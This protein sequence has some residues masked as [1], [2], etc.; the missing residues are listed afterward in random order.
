MHRVLGPLLI[1]IGV[2]APARSQGLP[3]YRSVNPAIASRS[4]LGFDPVSSGA[5]GWHTALR[6]DYGNV[7]EAQTRERADY[8]LDAELIRLNFSLARNVG[9]W[10]LSG[11]V[12]IESGQSGALDSYINWWHGIFGFQEGRREG[13][14][15]NEYEYFI[16]FPD[17]S[18][19]SPPLPGTALGDLRLSA[20]FKHKPNW[21]TTLVAA[22]PTNTRPDG[23]GLETIAVGI[24]TAARMELIRDRL[25]WEG[26]AGV[27]Y[28]PRAGDLARWQQPWVASATAGAR[29]RFLGRQSIY[30]NFLFHTGPWQSTTLSALGGP[31]FALDFGFLLKPGDGGPEILAGMV[32]DL[33]PYGPA[34][35]LVLRL[36]VRW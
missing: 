3:A 27:G 36:G 21:Q 17:S 18:R 4:P 15:E 28:T 11:A 30:T 20:G 31:D 13:R 7:L 12:P 29:L 1:L 6:L 22:F 24:E 5:P 10:H 14:P 34:V 16:Q 23:W 33:Y 32:E 19:V 2:A 9:R 26:S 8:L 35:D 25:T